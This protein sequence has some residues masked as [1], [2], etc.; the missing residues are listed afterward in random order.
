[1]L[2]DGIK[3]HFQ[4]SVKFD[5]ANPLRIGI[6]PKGK[7]ASISWGNFDA[8]L[9]ATG[10]RG[11][12]DE[13]NLAAVGIEAQKDGRIPV[14]ATSMWTGKARIYAAG[15]AA[16]DNEIG[17]GGLYPTG[18][19]QAVRAIYSMFMNEWPLGGFKADYYADVPTAIWTNPDVAYVGPTEKAARLRYGAEAVGCIQ[20]G[21][22][23]TVRYAVTPKDGFLKIIFLLDGGRVLSCHMMGDDSNEMIHYGAAMV[24][25]Q[26]TVFDVV[27][28]ITA[29]VTYQEVYRIA[30]MEAVMQVQQHMQRLKTLRA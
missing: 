2:S 22:D 11:A 16:G 15:D 13:V 21:Y 23:T 27:R 3:F 26:H 17:P 30:A 1:M 12:T 9:G 7:E 29:G 14:H 20:M 24:N 25:G 18:R 28:E 6:H 19:A 8:F 4:S 5:S 10:R